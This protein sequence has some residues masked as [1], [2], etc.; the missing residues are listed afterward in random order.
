[1]FPF[2]QPLIFFLLNP[3][4]S[5]LLEREGTKKQRECKQQQSTEQ[6]EAG[7]KVKKC[8]ASKSTNASNSKDS[9]SNVIK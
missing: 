7:L 6:H 8:D 2:S 9:R 5:R 1:M 3:S 4:Y